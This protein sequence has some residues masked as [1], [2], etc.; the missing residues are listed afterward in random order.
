MSRTKNI[1]IKK[2]VRS[3]HQSENTHSLNIK[4]DNSLDNESLDQHSKI[5]Q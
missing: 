1:K 4:S 5:E 2:L 3:Q